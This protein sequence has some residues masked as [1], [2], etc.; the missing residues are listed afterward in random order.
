MSFCPHHVWS[1]RYCQQCTP[2]SGGGIY[3]PPK[4][5]TEEEDLELKKWFCKKCLGKHLAAYE[6]G[7]FCLDCGQ[8]DKER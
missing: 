2:N 3:V 5:S 8:E 7:L 6:A 1:S 4:I